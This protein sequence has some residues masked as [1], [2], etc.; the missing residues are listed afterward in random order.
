PLQ[1]PADRQH[2]QDRLV[3]V[4]STLAWARNRQAA[5][6]TDRA[7][8]SRP[9]GDPEFDPD[10]ETSVQPHDT[11]YTALPCK[12]KTVS[13]VGH[14]VEAAAAELRLITREIEFPLTV[15]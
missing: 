2:H 6:F 13:Q 8:V 9:T 15:D 7:T 4:E 1:G 5:Q 11:L 14:D 12:V 10:T 3:S